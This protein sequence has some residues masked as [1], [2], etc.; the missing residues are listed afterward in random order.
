MI[1]NPWPVNW[2]MTKPEKRFK[3]M[4]DQ[5][6][7]LCPFSRL[8]P[9]PCGTTRRSDECRNCFFRQQGYNAMG[10]YKTKTIRVCDRCGTRIKDPDRM[11]YSIVRNR[12]GDY[13]SDMELCLSCS[14]ELTLWV[15]GEDFPR[16]Q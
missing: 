3:G 6:F 5:L 4:K 14:Q 15:N 10:Q 16:V 9:L 13:L 1:L 7:Q 11:L 12:T 8:Y 2:T